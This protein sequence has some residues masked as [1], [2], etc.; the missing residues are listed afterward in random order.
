M[1]EEIDDA[2]ARIRAEQFVEQLGDLLG[3]TPARP[4]AGAKRG[5]RIEG[6][7]PPSYTIGMADR[8]GR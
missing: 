1:K 2:R 3:P 6:R 8:M 7:M 4:A 5:S